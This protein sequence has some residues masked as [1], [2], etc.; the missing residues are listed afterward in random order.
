QIT[1]ERGRVAMACDLA[2][3][4]DYGSIPPWLRAEP[5]VVR[6]V[7]G[8]DLVV[9]RAPVDVECRRDRIVAEFKVDAGQTLSFTLQYGVAHQTEPEPLDP[10]AAIAV[11]EAYWREWIGKFRAPTD[12]PEP[13]KRS[14]L[15]LQA[16]TEA[17]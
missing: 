13:V 16:L 4:F 1:G 9:L 7:V 14:L 11:T 15:T 3:R 5:R 17:E 6:G 2:L 12:W 8:P 10:A